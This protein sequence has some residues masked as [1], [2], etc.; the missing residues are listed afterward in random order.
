MTGPSEAKRP[1]R[2]RVL[3]P[4]ERSSEVLFGL[5]MVLSFTLSISA[6]SAGHEEIREE[7]RT[8]L[9]GALGCNLAWG[10]V[11]AIMYLIN[12]LGERGRGMK[13]LRDV[14]GAKSSEEAARVISEA[15]PDA[16]ASCLDERGFELIRARAREL[17]EPPA[18]PT[19]VRRD[20]AG[21]LGVFLLVFL[22]T[23]PVVIPFVFMRHETSVQNAH[24]AQRIS[25]GIAI[26]MLFFTGVSLG[27]YSFGKPWRTGL[28]M[29]AL[30]LVLVAITMALGG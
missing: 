26:A 28:V 3:D 23:L 11:D 18:K 20:F 12:T 19:L 21:A 16:I 1:E 4:V 7:I 10:I 9:F 24:L 8:M 5:I 14:R 25:N 22:S 2:K 13:A 17:P 30:G 29:V 27:R 15:L 6:A